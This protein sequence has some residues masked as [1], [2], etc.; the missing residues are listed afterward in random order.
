MG[1]SVKQIKQKN[2]EKHYWAGRYT[3]G[4]P[5]TFPTGVRTSP[6]H[7]AHV[8]WISIPHASLKEILR[9]DAWARSAFCLKV[10]KRWNDGES[11][12]RLS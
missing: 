4:P 10:K 7:R 12:T 2:N 6:K 9:P 1:A 3:K 5:H 11:R 8:A